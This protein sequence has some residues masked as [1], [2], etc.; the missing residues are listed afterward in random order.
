MLNVKIITK[1]SFPDGMAATSRVKCY[2]RALAEKGM[3]VSV[4]A[5]ENST[6]SPQKKGTYEGIPYRIL[7]QRKLSNKP[8]NYFW[9]FTKS[10][11][12]AIHTLFSCKKNDVFIIYIS[13]AIPKLILVFFL[14]ILGKKTLIELNEYPFATEGNKLTK[15]NWVKKILRGITF[16][17]VF[18]LSDGFLV[19]SEPLGQVVRKYVNHPKILKIPVLTETLPVK[20]KKVTAQETYLFHAGS[21]SEQKDGIVHVFKA[22]AQAR[23]Y[24]KEKHGVD[25]K[26]YLTNKKTQAATWQ[27]IEKVIAQYQLKDSIVITGFLSNEALKKYE[28]SALALVVNKPS[29]FQNKYNFPTKLATYLSSGNPVII[30]ANDLELNHFLKHK[31][32]AYVTLP[33]KDKA[34]A[35]A[36][37][38]CYENPEQARTI[39]ENAYQTAVNH[40]YYRQ[41]ANPLNKFIRQL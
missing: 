27:K 8:L 3:N 28:Q 35:K 36:I 12:L 39:S 21:L 24:L 37:I 40:F 2:A 13:E 16:Y 25:M 20:Q 23:K 17:I 4:L 7:L 30:G 10:F 29:S 33:N 6:D 19:I 11:C 5:P 41:Q 34:M 32:N 1:A 18:P 38:E 31:E 15:I 26:F 14:K 9:A 22:Y